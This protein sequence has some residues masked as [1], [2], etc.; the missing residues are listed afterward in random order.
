MSVINI[1]V[2]ESVEQVISGI[3]KSVSISTNI[4]SSIFYT[5]D[6]TTPT[7]FSNI[8]TGSLILPIDKL[9]VTLSIFATNGV[10]SSPVITE[11]YKTNILNN[12]RLPHSATDV[13]AGKIMP[14]LYPF[15]TEPN[16]PMGHFLN[17][18]DAGVTVFNPELPSAPTTFGSDGYPSG[19]TNEPYDL[20]NYN[21]VYS[22]TDAIGNPGVGNLPANV[23]IKDIVPSPETTDQ[24][25][26][27]F[28]PRALVI[29]QDF[30]KEDPE[31]P[32]HINRQFFSLEDPEKNVN[33]FYTSGLDAPSTSGSFLRSHYNPRDG[34]YTYYYLDTWTNR[35]II[36]K[37]PYKPTGS[38]DGNMAG[39]FF[40][41]S[42]AANRCHEW[43]AG[44]YRTLF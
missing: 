7:L 10:D 27:M 30:S 3:P 1:I 43:R 12:T 28:D 33:A 26:N 34:F 17:P 2:E 23:K 20:L 18:G 15:G 35:W 4:A 40:G 5:L 24:F 41:R 6:G 9:S 19:F 38:F 36:S 42:N 31:G 21:I 32:A 22:T 44:A 11:V 14:D 13:E 16:Q 37:T 39:T 29:F 25:G 8:Y